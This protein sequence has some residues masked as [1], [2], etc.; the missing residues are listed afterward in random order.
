LAAAINP[1][2]RWTESEYLLADIRDFTGVAAAPGYGF[3]KPPEPTGR[4]DPPV[5]K[6]ES[7]LASVTNISDAVLKARFA[8][9]DRRLSS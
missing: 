4:P 5:E 7:S 2:H 1:L 9:I 6:R 8:E 3:K